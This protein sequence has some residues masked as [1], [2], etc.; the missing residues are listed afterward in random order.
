[1]LNRVEMWKNHLRI[2]QQCPPIQW[3]SLCLCSSFAVL[4]YSKWFALFAWEFEQRRAAA[5]WRKS[6]FYFTKRID[7]FLFKCVNGIILQRI[8][9]VKP[10]YAFFMWSYK[11]SWTVLVRIR[12]QFVLH[13]FSHVVEQWKIKRTLLI[14]FTNNVQNGYDRQQFDKHDLLKWKLVMLIMNL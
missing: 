6:K 1:M 3:S 12:I 9:N 10:F 2:V 7:K 4:L 13:Q 11:I 5:S 8:K 14:F